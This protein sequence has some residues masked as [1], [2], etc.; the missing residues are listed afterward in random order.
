MFHDF[1]DAKVP[2]MTANAM[3]VRFIDAPGT[4]G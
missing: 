2:A 3:D 1:T 4:V